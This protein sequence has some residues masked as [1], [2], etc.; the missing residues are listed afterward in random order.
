MTW[1]PWR[2][3]AFFYDC[4]S[5]PL[6]SQ[7]GRTLSLVFALPSQQRY[8]TCTSSVRAY[9]K[10]VSQPCHDWLKGT[11]FLCGLLPT[12]ATSF[13]GFG[14]ERI[15]FV[16]KRERI[17]QEIP[18]PISQSPKPVMHERMVSICACLSVCPV[19]KVT[20]EHELLNRVRSPRSRIA[21]SL[22]PLESFFLWTNFRNLTTARNETCF[23]KTFLTGRNTPIKSRRRSAALPRRRKEFETL[24]YLS[25]FLEILLSISHSYLH[26]SNC[27]TAAARGTAHLKPKL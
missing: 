9:S 1:Y 21:L 22:G 26:R 8:K 25:L 10:V 20:Y 15:G 11:S 23:F 7:T 6:S 17:G 5:S 19:P 18:S 14:G 2:R 16:D 24:L 12:R 27:D 3:K 4:S 13:Q